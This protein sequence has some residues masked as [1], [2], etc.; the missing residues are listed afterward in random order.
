[1]PPEFKGKLSNAW[2]YCRAYNRFTRAAYG[3]MATVM[4]NRWAIE[5][6]IPSYMY[7]RL[8]EYHKEVSTQEK[9]DD[10]RQ[11]DDVNCASRVLTE[12]VSDFRQGFDVFS[13]AEIEGE[14]LCGVGRETLDMV[15]RSAFDINH[16]K[17]LYTK[18]LVTGRE[19]IGEN[20]TRTVFKFPGDVQVIGD[21]YFDVARGMIE[22]LSADCTVHGSVDCEHVLTAYLWY[23]CMADLL[24]ETEGVK[25]DLMA[26]EERERREKAAQ[27]ALEREP[28]TKPVT[29]SPVP[30]LGDVQ[31]REAIEGRA[32]RFVEFKPVEM[33]YEEGEVV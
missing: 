18:M 23:D 9:W 15:Q 29:P 24:Y 13:E 33:E 5:E 32:T 14:N 12:L 8:A 3:V 21:H 10:L 22:I 4:E 31:R 7:G 11:C 26:L 2:R 30:R 27:E 28:A 20:V 1:M 6:P 16:I 17:G 19:D 25:T